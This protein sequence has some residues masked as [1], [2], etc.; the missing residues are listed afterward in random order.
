MNA[1]E[2]YQNGNLS[3]AVGQL[4]LDVK[5]SPRDL[6]SRTFL[7]ELLCFEGE[8]DRAERQLDV[9]GELMDN[10]TADVGLQVY[11]N[12]IAGE[13]A[14]R[15]FFNGGRMEPKFFNEPPRYTSLHI[16]AV[17]C[18]AEKH[19]DQ[20]EDRLQQAMT[21][22][23][24]VAGTIDGRRFVA[25]KDSDDLTSPF[26]EVFSQSDYFWIPFEQIERLEFQPPRSL[27]NLLW[28]P[29]KLDLHEKA[30][31]E[32]F[33]PVLY[34]GSSDHAD[35]RI[36]LGRM[37]DWQPMTD[38][39]GSGVGQRMLLA[40]DEERSLLEIRNIDFDSGS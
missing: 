18:L 8:F 6:R 39:F 7:F 35:A 12:L 4:T 17:G 19:F 33:V 30:L 10:P 11:R 13:K 31:G 37:T 25:V 9:I 29:A 28:L 34:Q 21:F 26:L 20:V 2:H 16:D 3:D 40:D 27:R 15:M 22:H 14:R 24:A 36:R 38:S 1:Q 5:T 32:V 23:P